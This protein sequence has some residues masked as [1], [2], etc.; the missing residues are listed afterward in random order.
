[1]LWSVCAYLKIFF[2]C[3]ALFAC[4]MKNTYLLPVAEKMA[5]DLMARVICERIRISWAHTYVNECEK[6]NVTARHG[7]RNH[8]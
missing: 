1:M 2:A 8:S 5:Q 4:R 7:K 3:L 6:K